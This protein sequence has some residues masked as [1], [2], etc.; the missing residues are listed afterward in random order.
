MNKKSQGLQG[1]LIFHRIF[2]YIQFTT[3]RLN[4]KYEFQRLK[5]IKW[6]KKHDFISKYIKKYKL[7][8]IWAPEKF[9]YLHNEK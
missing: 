1:I 5:H 6:S 2:F 4:V 8:I 9:P 7:N 3:Q